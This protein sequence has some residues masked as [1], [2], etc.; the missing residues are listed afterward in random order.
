MRNYN[1]L[2]LPGVLV[3]ILPVLRAILA[4]HGEARER[5]RKERAENELREAKAAE[6]AA[7]AAA[8][9]EREAAK[10]AEEAAKP[11]RKRGRPRK[12]P[13]AIQRTEI[14]SPEPVA[15]IAEPVTPVAEPVAPSPRRPLSICGNNAFVGEV[16]AFTGTLRGMTRR[17]AIEAVK[18]NG[19]RAYENMTAATTILVVGDKP[20][21]RKLDLADK[22]PSCR[23]IPAIE[24]EIMRTR[25][26]TLSMAEFEQYVREKYNVA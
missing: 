14:I 5:R 13:E 10:A 15:V 17:E 12:T 23:K 24:F 6:D 16:V 19:G 9:A 8:K 7:K 1:W 21:Q 26:L 11:Q 25:P 2:F 4:V 22:W 20:G 3:L 18:A